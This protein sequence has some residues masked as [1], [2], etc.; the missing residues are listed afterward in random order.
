MNAAAPPSAAG[1]KGFHHD[2]AEVGGLLTGGIATR[3]VE[4]LTD[5]S[6]HGIWWVPEWKHSVVYKL[7]DTWACFVGPCFPWPRFGC[8]RPVNRCGVRFWRQ[9]FT[10]AQW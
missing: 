1:R 8:V 4:Y 7:Q 3:R 10:R 5:K 9:T 6:Q 2:G